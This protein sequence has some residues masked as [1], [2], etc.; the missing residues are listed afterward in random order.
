MR[1]RSALARSMS[2]YSNICGVTT[3]LRRTRMRLSS[4]G[5][6]TCCSISASAVLTLRGLPADIR[7]LVR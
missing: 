5:A 3:S 6:S 7:P 2:W 4:S 1:L